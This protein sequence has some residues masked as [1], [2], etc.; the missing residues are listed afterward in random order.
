MNVRDAMAKTIGTAAP[1][2]PVGRVAQIMR[3]EDCGFVP[4]V[5]GG[6]VVG[7]V[8]DRDIVI[9][10]LAMGR[11]DILDAPIESIMTTTVF[12]IGPDADLAD[13]AHVM[14]EHEVRRLPVME[15]GRLIG[16]LSYG[17]L[18]QAL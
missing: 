6:D 7:V 9:R 1:S 13:A 5:A 14:A 10:G 18:E 4:I 16:V 17:N 11:A 8:T 15:R 12:P 3:T 2:D